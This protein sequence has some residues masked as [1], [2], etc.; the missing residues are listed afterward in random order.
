MCYV[1]NGSMFMRFELNC[2]NEDD[3]CDIEIAP[4]FA[5]AEI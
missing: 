2:K 3:A 4:A 1:E 5:I